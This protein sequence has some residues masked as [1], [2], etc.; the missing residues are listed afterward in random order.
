MR[1]KNSVDAPELQNGS[2]ESA[3]AWP[4]VTRKVALHSD[5]RREILSSRHHRKGL[6]LA[7]S[8]ERRILAS[9]WQPRELNWWIGTIFAVGAA[10]FAIA[11]M[12]YLT[13]ALARI[14]GIEARGIDAL[15][16]TGSIPFTTAAYLQLFQAAN[17]PD[18]G[19]TAAPTSRKIWFGWRPRDIGWNSCALQFAGTLLF[20]VNTFNGMNPDMSWLKEDL[21]VWAPDM[22]GSVLFL[23]S[24]YL[25]F[26]ETCHKH[27]AWKP[28]SLSWWITSFNLLG[29]VAF[30][31]S[32]FFAFVSPH[33]D[34]IGDATLAIGFTLIGALGF[35]TGSLLMLLESTKSGTSH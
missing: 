3:E 9:L 29:C 21:T 32:A 35:L 2:V 31:V 25:A 16:F 33:E 8:I 17:A 5:G 24:G 20:N 18:W 30:M 34:G 26:A 1:L 12:L 14:W 7:A 13:P 27:F 23:A 10:L 19:H 15:Y 28:E 4:F 22:V 11:S 6:I